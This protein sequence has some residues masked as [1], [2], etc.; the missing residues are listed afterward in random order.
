MALKYSEE[1]KGLLSPITTKVQGSPKR[2]TIKTER[3]SICFP[4][5]PFL[6]SL[7]NCLSWLFASHDNGPITLPP[8]SP[9]NS[10]VI[11]DAFRIFRLSDYTPTGS[12]RWG[13]GN[14]GTFLAATVARGKPDA[15]RN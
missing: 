14:H 8:T 9:P 13:F 11:D 3:N 10:G 12:H 5:P 4:F 2:K 15:N 1:L 7:L 6:P